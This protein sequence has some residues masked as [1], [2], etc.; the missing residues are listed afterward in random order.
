MKNNFIMGLLF[1]CV[2]I[3]SVTSMAQV[4]IRDCSF[5]EGV[6]L[7]DGQKEALS[8]GSCLSCQCIEK[9]FIKTNLSELERKY[10]SELA[11]TL[12]IRFIQKKIP[13]FI[14][15]MKE[16]NA[17]GESCRLDRLQSIPCQLDKNLEAE[18]DGIFGQYFNQKESSSC[19]PISTINRATKYRHFESDLSMFKVLLEGGGDIDMF[20]IAP[21]PLI[22]V[23]EENYNKLKNV[24]PNYGDLKTAIL[25]DPVLKSALSDKIDRKCE[26]FFEQMNKVLCEEPKN[27]PIDDKIFKD[28]LGFNKDESFPQ[29]ASFRDLELFTL[30]C[31]TESCKLK[32][33]S[34]LSLCIEVEKREG[35]VVDS[36]LEGESDILNSDSFISK[37]KEKQSI[38]ENYCP[39]LNCKD[40]KEEALLVMDAKKEQC[41]LQEPPRSLGQL[42]NELKCGSENERPLCKEEML[43][44]LFKNYEPKKD[45]PLP[46]PEQ[47]LAGRS[48][49]DVSYEEK[50]EIL[51]DYGYTDQSLSFLGKVGLKRAFGKKLELAGKPL[52]PEQKEFRELGRETAQVRETKREKQKT[53]ERSEKRKGLEKTSFSERFASKNNQQRT[54]Q[55]VPV[56]ASSNQKSARTIPNYENT[57]TKNQERAVDRSLSRANPQPEVS[58]ASERSRRVSSDYRELESE[59][60]SLREQANKIREKR[61]R[62][63]YE[64]K[65]AQLRNKVNQLK[66][67]E[68]NTE[69]DS[70][71][72]GSAYRSRNQYDRV[73]EASQVSNDSGDP[74]QK[75]L[76]EQQS[77][78][79][80]SSGQKNT[81]AKSEVSSRRTPASLAAKAGYQSLTTGESARY[82][83]RSS[84]ELPLLSLENLEELI[85]GEGFILGVREAE[86]LKR[87][88]ML[89]EKS[90]KN[91]LYRP[92]F[93]ENLSLE[94]KT[95]LFSSPFF[96]Q[97]VHPDVK[98]DL[99][100]S[101]RGSTRHSSLIKLLNEQI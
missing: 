17:P 28:L 92:L 19:F 93:D 94:T 80:P 42:I 20:D 32:D 89:P 24:N 7:D 67:G 101:M 100:E 36:L 87:I 52:T 10:R 56:A 25:N 6:T 12:R 75:S 99:L 79:A 1:I 9:S 57:L 23:Y 65:I 61:E 84:E 37:F 86:D 59:I 68:P 95:S 83:E 76:N 97:H 55:A 53:Q 81:G 66:N 90:G 13:E 8:S 16:F 26:R 98:K 64:D 91:V 31:Q 88:E 5:M 3:S 41:Q 74:D 72:R 78:R 15:L 27:I 30:R 58:T 69:R 60:R 34:H 62:K 96:Q 38:Y 45:E 70:S 77:E 21:D 14:N 39:L 43:V 11:E 2:S 73:S 33:Q 46:P 18:V 49:E 29:H 50:R 82:L 22:T 44:E 47:L 48:Y 35:Y 51:K 63:V 54:K 40:L 71:S 4:Q 85:P